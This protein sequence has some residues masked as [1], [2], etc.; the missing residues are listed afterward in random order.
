M[1]LFFAVSLECHTVRSNYGSR[2]YSENSRDTIARIG[3]HSLIPKHLA[4]CGLGARA[5]S[6]VKAPNGA[7]WTHCDTGS[8][9]D[10]RELTGEMAVCSD[11]TPLFLL[12][13]CLSNTFL[14]KEIS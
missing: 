12:G 5:L 8:T 14:G 11:N 10:S 4:G 1:F 3:I 6:T 9:P 13:P 2:R 7:I